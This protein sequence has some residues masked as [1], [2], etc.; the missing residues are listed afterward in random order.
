MSTLAIGNSKRA[1][2]GQ[3]MRIA[4]LAM[5][6]FAGLAMVVQDADAQRGGGRGGG[7]R[8]FGGAG[9]G[10]ALSAQKGLNQATWNPRLES[11]F[12]V[13]PRIV[14]WGGG[15]GRGGGP[16][17]APGVYTV[18][19][20]SGDWSQEQTF[21]LSTDPRLPQM[22]EAEGALQLKMAMEVGTRIKDLYDTLAKLRDAKQQAAQIGDKA[23]A[24]AV[25][26]A[27]KKLNAQL[28]AVEGDITQ[29][30]GEAGQDSLNFP[31][32]IDNQ[33][34]ALY[35]NIVQLERRLNKS[36]KERYT[37]LRPATD[38][39]MERAAGVL[40]ADVDAFNAVASK[41]GAGTVIV[42]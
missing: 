12:T 32:R 26:A 11:P 22:T 38:D 29:L 20:A 30:Q 25:T 24:S 15:G 3:G 40:K 13:P 35:S 41:A 37:D 9:G 42:K 27:A 4:L 23:G 16:K 31:G 21:R 18:K 33:W 19:L 17:A 2:L 39:L 36:V 7:G 1:G 28:V 34:V 6:G 14:M 10:A 8:G 5:V